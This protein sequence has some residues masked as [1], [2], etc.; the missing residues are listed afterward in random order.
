MNAIT[1]RIAAAAALLAAPALI[2]L[3]T[4]SGRPRRHRSSANN[5]PAT[6]APQHHEAFPHQTHI[7]Q[8]RHPR[9]TT[10]TRTTTPTEVGGVT[11]ARMHTHPGSRPFGDYPV[12]AQCFS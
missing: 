3:G 8:A 1:R 4:A 2:A 6:S 5:G 10:A 11:R 12:S 7:P 9:A